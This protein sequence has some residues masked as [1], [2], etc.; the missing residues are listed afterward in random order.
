[1]VVAGAGLLAGLVAWGAHRYWEAHWG[2]ATFGL[3]AGAVFAP[4][5]VGGLVYWGVT[6][7][8][9]V[10]TAKDLLAVVCGRSRS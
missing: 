1:V 8:G 9:R 2:H 3:K 4:M 5:A 10:T 7:A 6:L